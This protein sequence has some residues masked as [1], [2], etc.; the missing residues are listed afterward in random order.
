M[1]PVAIT[2]LGLTALAGAIV[3]YVSGRAWRSEPE[4]GTTLA[5]SEEWPVCT[6]M[7]ALDGDADWAQ[8]DADFAAGKKALAAGDWD[9]AVAALKLAALREPDN[10][11]IQNYIGYAYRRL[12]RLEAAFAHYRQAI[13]LN[14][15]HRSAHEHMGEAHL[16]RGDVL[17][18]RAHLVA[19]EGICLIPCA[20]Y[21]D[22]KRAVAAHER[23][24][25]QRAAAQ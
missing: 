3:L 13:S 1:R 20:E 22:L 21:E 14:P 18:A 2:A 12:Q 17:Q 25:L 4:R 16:A 11:D 8:L 7:G 10:A 9:A 15:R 6:A 24:A 19:L 5:A 23:S